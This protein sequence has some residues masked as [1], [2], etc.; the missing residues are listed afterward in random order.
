MSAPHR[1]HRRPGDREYDSCGAIPARERRRPSHHRNLPHPVVAR[2]AASTPRH[3]SVKAIGAS[4][5]TTR[6][7]ARSSSP[8]VSMN[9]SAAQIAAMLSAPVAPAWSATRSDVVQDRF[10]DLDERRAVRRRH[11]RAPWHSGH[12]SQR[13]L[14][15]TRALCSPAARPASTSAVASPINPGARRIA[16]EPGEQRAQHAGRGLRQS[17]GP[18]SPELPR[19]PP[20]GWCMHT[21][22]A[23]IVMLAPASF[24]QGRGSFVIR[25][26]GDL[27]HADA[28]SADDPEWTLLTGGVPR[29]GPAARSREPRSC[30][31]AEAA[32][33]TRRW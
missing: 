12:S 32:P 25:R 33:R 8:A 24:Q 9:A 20:S 27:T 10:R 1:S 17:Q 2:A 4:Q 26:G 5:R 18:I 14:A 23:A 11:T 31:T 13:L 19:G 21:S 7:T 15:N 22:S 30:T 3:R 16:V 28:R 6:G 29:L